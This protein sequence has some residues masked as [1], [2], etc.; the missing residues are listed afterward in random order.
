MTHEGGGQDDAL[1][2]EVV[3]LRAQVAEL[4]RAAARHDDTA[5]VSLAERED[6]LREAERLA[7]FGTWTW[8]IQSGRVSWSE[9]MYRILGL[10]PDLVL[11]TVETFFA[12]VHPQDRQR[13]IE[14]AEQ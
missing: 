12:A 3:A 14:T 2:R 1:L 7:H 9:E 5:E 6:L 4:Q 11:P 10:H 13:V 8:D